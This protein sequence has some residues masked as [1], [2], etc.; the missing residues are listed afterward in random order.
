MSDNC[1]ILFHKFFNGYYKELVTQ[2]Y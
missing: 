2:M 1:K